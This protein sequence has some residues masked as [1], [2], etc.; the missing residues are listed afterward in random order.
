[1]DTVPIMTASMRDDPVVRTLQPLPEAHRNGLL[2]VVAVSGASLISVSLLFLHL[3]VKLVRWHLKSWRQRRASPNAGRRP[4]TVDLSLGLAP[5]HFQP[6]RPGVV[7]PQTARRRSAAAAP[8]AREPNQ[9]VVLLYNLLLADL[10]QSIA[11]V[12]SAA[13]LRED[14]VLVGTP[15]CWAQGFFISNGDLAVSLFIT[16]IAVHTYLVV[17]HEWRPTQKALIMSCICLWMFTYLMAAIG[18]LGTVNG[19]AVGG[20]YVRAAAWCWVNNRLETVRLMTHYVYIFF[21]L[22]ITSGFYIAIVVNLYS[23]G[24]L[25]RG[26]CSNNSVESLPS[27]KQAAKAGESLSKPASSSS[28]SST[29]TTRYNSTFLVYPLIYVLCTSPLAIGRAWTMSGRRASI[30][31]FCAAGALI[32]ANGILDVLIWGCTRRDIVFGDVDETSDSLGLDSFAFMRTPRDRKYGNIIVV[33]GAMGRQQK[34]QK[35]QQQQQRT[36]TGDAPRKPGRSRT[37][38][39]GG[40]VARARSLSRGRYG[41]RR[42]RRAWPPGANSQEGLRGGI[43]METVTT[44]V[45]EEDLDARA[46]LFVSPEDYIKVTGSAPSDATQAGFGSQDDSETDPGDMGRSKDSSSQSDTE[47][48]KATSKHNR[49]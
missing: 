42:G 3:T 32:S 5:E 27:Q 23:R 47:L 39:V 10:H 13:W 16:A 25:Q 15:T 4:P 48:Q 33:E 41:A 46:G 49:I 34:Q 2:A 11:F 21:S 29:D 35:Q 43:T 31:Y 30:P 9:F 8:Q 18:I 1:M 7:A 44:V 20:F 38:A 24:R 40:A 14:G 19:G 17:V 26:L 6:G 12:M 22:A 36:L 28:S 45:V 37:R